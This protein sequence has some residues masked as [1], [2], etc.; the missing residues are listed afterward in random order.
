M[1]SGNGRYKIEVGIGQRN[2]KRNG[3]WEYEKGTVSEMRYGKWEQEVE[4]GSW[5]GKWE[6]GI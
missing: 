1:G 6:M 3:K 5:K 2:G 4:M